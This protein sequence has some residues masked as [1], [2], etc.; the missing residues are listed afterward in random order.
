MNGGV[1]DKEAKMTS[2]ARD[3][4]ANERT[5]LAWIRTSLGIMVFGFVIEKFIL[6]IR[7]ITFLFRK[8]EAQ[9]LPDATNQLFQELSSIFGL[10]LVI[11]GMLISF[12]AFMKYKSVEKQIENDS[13]QPSSFLN[14]ML[15]LSILLIGVF[16]LIYL[17]P[18]SK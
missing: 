6:F 16:L 2:R 12:L 10:F 3:H 15:L 9:I 4:M 1:R 8:S 5:F 18:F 11:S 13:Y 14:V 7:Q 17:N